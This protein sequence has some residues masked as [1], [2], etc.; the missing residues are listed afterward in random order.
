MHV[1]VHFC[2]PD[3]DLD[4][5][6]TGVLEALVAEN[7]QI[8]LAVKVCLFAA[9]SFDDQRRVREVNDA[10]SLGVS[11]L[12]KH[13]RQYRVV[14]GRGRAAVPAKA[15]SEGGATGPALERVVAVVGR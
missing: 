14:L 4:A 10:R 7:G 3:L 15:T 12:E 6:D 9:Q 13:V 11:R 5:E 1:D 8:G 2:D